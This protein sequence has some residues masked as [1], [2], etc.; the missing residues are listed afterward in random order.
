MASTVDPIRFDEAGAWRWHVRTDSIR[1]TTDALSGLWGRVAQEASADTLGGA[2][3][4][5]LAH[6]DP[7][8]AAHMGAGDHEEGVR[9]RT[10]TSVL[11]LV[12]VPPRPELVDRAKAILGGCSAETIRSND[13]LKEHIKNG[14]SEVENAMADILSRPRRKIIM[15]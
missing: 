5:E 8:L 11:T 12:M 15:N 6:G 4:H 2:A 13:Q 14:M 10:R 1:A 9:V 3:G 7:R